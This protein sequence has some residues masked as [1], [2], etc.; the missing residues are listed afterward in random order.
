MWQ[1]QTHDDYAQTEDLPNYLYSVSQRL[2]PA[3]SSYSNLATING[4]FKEPMKYP[5]KQND[6]DNKENMYSSAESKETSVEKKKVKDATT[7]SAS[8]STISKSSIRTFEDY[9]SV[10]ACVYFHNHTAVM[11]E[12]EDKDTTVEHICDTLINSDELGINKQLFSQ[13]F[14]LWMISP[15]LELQLKPLHKPYEIRQRWTHLLE[16]YSH[17]SYHKQQRDEPRLIFQRNVFFSQQLEEKI[18]DQKIL[19]LLY[20]EARHNILQGRYPCE[21]VH[22]IMLGGIQARI[23]LGPYNPQEHTIHFFREKQAKYLPLHVRKSSTWSWLPISSKNS[24]EVK[25]LEQFKRIPNATTNRKLMKKY[26]EFCWSLPFYGCAYFEGQIEQPVTGL[27]SL[28]THQD[29]PILVAINAEGLY[30]MD[31]IKYVLLLGL[32]FEEFSWEYARPSR[33]ENPNCLPCLFIQFNVVENGTTVSKILQIFSRQAS[34]MDTL[35]TTFMKQTKSKKIDESDK[36]LDH[37]VG[38]IE[39][40]SSYIM[41]TM[42]PST[43]PCLSNKLNRLTLATFDEN[44][45]CIGQM[46]SWSFSF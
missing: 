14:T 4:G 39:P 22:Y 13:I 21:E 28:M 23:E 3:N 11:M 31:D 15:L 27:T 36:S 35:I 25:L 45:H 40:H 12:M 20:E 2:P 34:L 10:H 5:T 38:E 9:R 26:L 43:L 7:S 8:T 18:K 46:G 19:E 37:V 1:N 42:Y 44:G 32:K 29:Q 41:S 16:Q 17:A 30:I 24:A 6:W 33:E